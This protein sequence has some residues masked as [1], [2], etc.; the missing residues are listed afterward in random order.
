MWK[1]AR[2]VRTFPQAWPRF[3]RIILFTLALFTS[4]YLP[5]GLAN[6]WDGG[7]RLTIAT[8]AY[9]YPA[10]VVVWGLW[11]A[12]SVIGWSVIGI[13]GANS[14][15]FASLA[16]LLDE[17]SNKSSVDWQYIALIP[18]TATGLFHLLNLWWLVIF[19]LF[20]R[21]DRQLPPPATTRQDNG[22]M[23][24]Q[25]FRSWLSPKQHRLLLGGAIACV[26]LGILLTIGF[27]LLYVESHEVSSGLAARTHWLTW[28]VSVLE[29]PTPV[30]H[31]VSVTALGYLLAL[32]LV[33]RRSDIVEAACW[34][35]LPGQLLTILL[36]PLPLLAVVGTSVMLILG[37]LVLWRQGFPMA[38]LQTRREESP[39]LVG[40]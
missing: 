9:F 18:V 15:V 39:T 33:R 13:H 37:L 12:H 14:A 24:E 34:L 22:E 30:F 3:V 21:W 16:L 10:L 40:T 29:T 1:V 26:L 28:P 6:S 8:I 4:P 27:F 35:L 31:M 20:W 32:G 11:K 23:S 7:A 38:L 17:S 25:G 5:L 19:M 36:G 2:Y